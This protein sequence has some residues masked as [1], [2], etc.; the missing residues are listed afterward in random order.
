M[1]IAADREERKLHETYHLPEDYLTERIEY[2]QNL[3][4]LA[5]S[6]LLRRLT[7]RTDLNDLRYPIRTHC[8]PVM[9]EALLNLLQQATGGLRYPETL[10]LC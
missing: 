5:F 6:Y 2:H 1:V 7:V 8:P 9:H 3:P 4:L 10:R